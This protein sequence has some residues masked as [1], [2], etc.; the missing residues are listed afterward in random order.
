MREN[1]VSRGL[2]PREIADVTPSRTLESAL[3][4]NKINTVFIIYVYAE[5]EKLIP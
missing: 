4:L 2:A 5:K 3:F 1:W